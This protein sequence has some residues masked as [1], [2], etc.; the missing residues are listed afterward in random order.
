MQ[1]L[2]NKFVEKMMDPSEDQKEAEALIKLFEATRFCSIGQS[3]LHTMRDS[4]IWLLRR[5]L[6]MIGAG[7][8]QEKAPDLADRG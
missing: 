8:T 1:A 2:L 7:D 6:V 3:D 5:Y 4:I